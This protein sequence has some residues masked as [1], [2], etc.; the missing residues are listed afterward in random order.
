[1][2]SA[3]VAL[4][5]AP[6]RERIQWSLR[7]SAELLRLLDLFERHAIPAL[8]FKGPAL[9]FALY[10]DV[11]M[12]EYCD[13]DVLLRPEDLAAAKHAL[14]AE[15][16]TTDLPSHAGREAAYLRARYELHFT[17]PD[18]AVPIEI[19][20]AF[21]PPSYCVP[22]DYPALWRR[23]ERQPFCGREV[24]ALPP[25]RSA[26]DALRAR[27]QTRLDGDERHPRHRA[28]ADNFSDRI[29]WPALLDQARA[30]GAR[31]I[32]LL[33]L[34]LAAALPDTP[35][36]PAPPDV[37]ALARGGP[38]RVAT[39]RTGPRG[40]L[41]GIRGRGQPAILYPH[42]RAPPRQ[43]GLLRASGA[44]AQRRR[45]F[46]PSSPSPAFFSV[47]PTAR[48]ARRGKIQPRLFAQPLIPAEGSVKYTAVYPGV[49]FVY[50]GLL[51]S[52]SAQRSLTVAPPE[53]VSC[54]QHFGATA[55]RESVALFNKS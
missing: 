34:S 43:A 32:L 21:L 40:A 28:A 49:S 44:Y 8:P 45:L 33:G 23:L 46:L 53:P 30:M 6:G 36:P 11:A 14:L 16:Y 51:I 52:S 15:G 47:L 4:A 22:F 37:L 20:Q 55:V 13:L 3:P 50:I 10:G 24:L 42:T 5:G 29:C 9:A 31:R 17:T 7:L 19:H 48:P 1:M 54:V 39:F 27:R 2:T 38:R 41:A 18:G 12:R 26:A 25:S 35:T